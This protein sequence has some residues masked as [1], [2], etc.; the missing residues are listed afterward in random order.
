MLKKTVMRHFLFKLFLFLLPVLTLA[1]FLEVIIRKTPNDY[2]L[3]RNYLDNNAHKIETLILGSSHSLYGL[4]PDY[5]DEHCFNASHV[6][7]TFDYDF[8]LLKKYENWSQLKT[9]ILP[10]SYF[11]FFE[12]IETTDES[13]RAKDY[14][15]YYDIGVSHQY[16]HHSEVLSI[17][18]KH[19]LKKVI[20]HYIKNLPTI[21]CTDLGWGTNASSENAVDLFSSGKRKAVKHTIT[22]QEC[23]QENKAILEEII[24]FC[25][26]KNINV[27]LFTPPAYEVYVENL[28]TN[29]LLKTIT[30]AN[31]IAEKY[32]NCTYTNLLEDQRYI[33][34]DF[35]DADHLNE[36][37]A[38]KLSK[39]MN[40]LIQ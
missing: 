17:S 26:T 33:P 13:W 5:F 24:G 15:L 38:K 12:R 27:V 19:N 16:K 10:I 8:A 25:K 34:E 37:G 23:F 35:F 20:N 22:N 40:E 28:D 29:Q 36:I 30:T 14:L 2:A 9:V 11:S 3:K 21:S 7:Q 31:Q 1:I 32:T 6:S 18:L 4:N 39:A